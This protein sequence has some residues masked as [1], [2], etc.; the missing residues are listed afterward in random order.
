M[1]RPETNPRLLD[2]NSASH[3]HHPA[4][5][6]PQKSTL[7][8][9]GN[10]INPQSCVFFSCFGLVREGRVNRTLTTV[11]NSCGGGV[12]VKWFYGSRRGLWTGKI[13]FDTDDEPNKRDSRPMSTSC[14]SWIGFLAY[15][16][17]DFL[18]IGQARPRFAFQIFRFAVCKR[19]TLTLHNILIPLGWISHYIFGICCKSHFWILS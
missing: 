7:Q 11:L 5:P 2:N 6:L 17:D 10:L 14:R 4:Q 9:L 8:N 19:H 18:R 15:C 12:Y 1:N 3:H 16:R 13:E